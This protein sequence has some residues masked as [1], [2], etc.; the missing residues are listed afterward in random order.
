MADL[1]TGQTDKSSAATVFTHI[2]RNKSVYSD[3]EH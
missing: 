2:H 3:A 1:S